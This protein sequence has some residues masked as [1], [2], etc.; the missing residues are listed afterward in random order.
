MKR[1]RINRLS[2]AERAELSQNLRDVVE[3]GL[4]RPSHSEFGSPI[5]FVRKH[6]G[7]L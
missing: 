4:I 5:L 6:D 2:H 7:L 3:V 1:Q